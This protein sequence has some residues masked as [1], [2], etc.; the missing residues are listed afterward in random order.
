MKILAKIVL[1]AL[2]MFGVFCLG[3]LHQFRVDK[4]EMN[5]MNFEVGWKY[6]QIQ[7]MQLYVRSGGQFQIPVFEKDSIDFERTLNK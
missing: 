6:C 7:T 1:M 4:K 2:A 5:R 3:Y